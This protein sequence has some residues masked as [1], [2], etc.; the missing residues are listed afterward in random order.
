MRR[1]LPQKNDVDRGIL[2]MRETG[3]LQRISR[4]HKEG[5]PKCQEFNQVGYREVTCLDVVGAYCLLVGGYLVAFAALGMEHLIHGL[6][7]ERT[8]K[9]KAIKSGKPPKSSNP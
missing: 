3:L 1:N 8:R 7:I 9:P 6:P 2:R 4:K 5:A